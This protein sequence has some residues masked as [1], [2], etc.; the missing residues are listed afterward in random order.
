M[1][2]TSEEITREI[3][4]LNDDTLKNPKNKAKNVLK[5]MK[6]L[7]QF[8]NTKEYLEASPED[9]LE[10]LTDCMQF[11]IDMVIEISRLLLVTSYKLRTKREL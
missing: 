1:T 6:L 2:M 11:M 3:D 4:K 5:Q 10:M 8:F 9:K 7:S